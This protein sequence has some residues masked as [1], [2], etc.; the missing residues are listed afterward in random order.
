MKLIDVS[1]EVDNGC[2]TCGTP[3]HEQV[4]ISQVGHL[5]KVGR[6]TSKIVLGSHSGTHID[7]PRH[8]FNDGYGVDKLD[9]MTLC[10][11]ISVIDFTHIGQGNCVQLE[12]LKDIKI[13]ERM[14]FRFGWY[15]YWKT[16]FSVD[17]AKYMVDQG[18]KLIALDTPSPDSG[19]CIN[20]KAEE[21]SPVHKLFLKNDIIIIEYLTNTNCIQR[22]KRHSIMALPLKI[23]GCD[24]SPGRVIIKED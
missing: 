10:G 20:E 1:M 19:K 6:N 5:E 15:V 8:F 21:D 9:L 22:G 18:L 2:M 11:E 3:W 13:S 14:L 17:A 23:A 12:D 4:E 16:D 24:G 7:A